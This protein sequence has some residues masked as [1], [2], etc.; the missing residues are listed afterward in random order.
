M[1]CISMQGQYWPFCLAKELGD[2]AAYIKNKISN[3]MHG[4]DLKHLAIICITI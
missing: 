1:T 4:N 2:G 3:H